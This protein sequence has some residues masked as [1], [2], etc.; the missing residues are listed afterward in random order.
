MSCVR[1]PGG[2]LEPEGGRLPPPQALRAAAFALS[3]YAAEDGAY[4]CATAAARQPPSS[5]KHPLS[6]VAGAAAARN[7]GL[8]PAVPERGPRRPVAR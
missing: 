2:R 7:S 3:S 6:L 4:F 1:A 5:P 8:A